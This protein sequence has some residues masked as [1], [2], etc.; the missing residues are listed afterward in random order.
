[1]LIDKVR[2]SDHITLPPWPGPCS[3]STQPSLL[4]RAFFALPDSIKGADGKPVNALLGTANL[5]L[6]E[7]EVHEPRA[8]VL[9]FGAEAAAYRVELLDS[10]HADRPEMP[11]DL[12]HQ[13]ADAPDFFGAFGWEVATHES[14]E[15]DD[16]LGTYA[17]LETEAGRHGAAVHRRPRHVPMR[18]EVGHRALREH[19]R[20][21]RRGGRRRGGREEVRDRPRAGARLHRPARRPLRRHPRAPRASARRPRPSCCESTARSRACSRR[22]SPRRGRSCA[23]RCS[24]RPTSFAP[25]RT[26]PPCATARSSARRT[27]RPT[28][29]GAA[30]RRASAA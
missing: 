24:A 4:Y 11:E 8:V 26:S 1:M 15:A 7:I 13:W 17:R 21:G 5:V 19:R 9:C 29:P 16:L 6:R 25:T 28:A 14:L 23:P 2:K 20:Q 30:P 12:V 3:Q 27:A 10:Y 22:R 18:V